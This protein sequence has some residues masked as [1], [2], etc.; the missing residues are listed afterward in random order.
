MG[1]PRRWR[2]QRRSARLNCWRARGSSPMN[3]RPNDELARA[4]VAK[5][6]D[7]KERGRPSLR[8]Q[9]LAC[10]KRRS[11]REG[12]KNGWER[13]QHP[14]TL[15]CWTRGKKTPSR[16]AQQSVRPRRGP[17]TMAADLVGPIPNENRQRTLQAASRATW[18]SAWDAVEMTKSSA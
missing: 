6:D 17:K 1:H 8:H 5:M 4:W 16:C 15:Y 10:W 3:S 13:E 9:K 12:A 11:P 18:R 14:S 7:E 2:H